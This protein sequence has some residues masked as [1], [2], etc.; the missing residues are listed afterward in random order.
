M[1]SVDPDAKEA[2]VATI[3]LLPG[4][5]FLGCAQEASPSKTVPSRRPSPARSETNPVAADV[6]L[7]VAEQPADAEQATLAAAETEKDAEETVTAGACDGGEDI[8]VPKGPHRSGPGRQPY[9]SV[10]TR[11]SRIQLGGATEGEARLKPP[12]DNSDPQRRPALTTRTAT[13]PSATFSPGPRDG[14]VCGGG[15]PHLPRRGR[16]WAARWPYRATCAIPTRPIPIRRPIR[17]TRCS[18]AVSPQL[19]GHGS[20]VCR[21]SGSR[22]QT[23]PRRPRHAGLGGVHPFGTSRGSDEFRQALAR[24]AIARV[25]GCRDAV[26]HEVVLRSARAVPNMVS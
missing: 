12:A 9:G 11:P 26:R 14:E 17:N 5:V 21:E 6:Q 2:V 23:R 24:A 15:L 1:N 22:R 13:T 20:L 19:Q 16:R 18:W 3:C 10:E 25:C 4:L 8:E 7:A